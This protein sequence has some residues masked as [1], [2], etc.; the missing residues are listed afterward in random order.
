MR[1]TSLCFRRGIDNCFEVMSNQLLEKNLLGE[2]KKKCQNAREYS[3][4]IRILSYL[5]RLVLRELLFRAFNMIET[6]F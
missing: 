3:F 6:L 5:L 2:C 4:H 1:M